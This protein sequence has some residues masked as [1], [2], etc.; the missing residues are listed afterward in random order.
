M[1]I[2]SGWSSAANVLCVRL[3]A[4]G[5]VLMTT[6]AFRALKESRPGGRI[7]LLTSPSGA[8]G[9]RLVP[10]IDDV[11]VYE[12]PWMKATASRTDSTADLAM[13]AEL[14][15]RAFDAAIIFTVYSQNPL[16]AALLCYL[17]EIPLRLAY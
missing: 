11:I 12:A 9:A 10:E 4:L 8:E 14:K 15:R 16:P 17:A 6:P 5:D 2:R 3:D 7:T 1:A 13:V